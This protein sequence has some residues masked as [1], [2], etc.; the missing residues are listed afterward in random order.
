MTFVEKIMVFEAA[1]VLI[2][3]LLVGGIF[4]IELMWY[5]RESAKP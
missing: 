3:T 2:E 4:V 5:R 1:L